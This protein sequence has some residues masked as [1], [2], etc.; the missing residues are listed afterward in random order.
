MPLKDFNEAD[1]RTIRALSYQLGLGQA[2]DD[3]VN[4]VVV[5]A[6][7]NPVPN[8]PTGDQFAQLIQT[9]QSGDRHISNINPMTNGQLS[10]KDQGGGGGNSQVIQSMPGG[11]LPPTGLIGAEQALSGGLTG[12]ESA[13][14]EGA[15]F[16][17][18]SLQSERARGEALIREGIAFGDQTLTTGRD[19]AQQEIMQ[20]Q[21]RFGSDALGIFDLASDPIRQAEQRALSQS[22]ARFDQAAAPMISAT[23]SGVDAN[24][25]M[26]AQSGALGPEAQ[27]AAYNQFN[28]S[29]GQQY[30]Q[31]QAE[32]GLLR[33]Q[34]AIGGLGGGR[35]RQELQRQA[36]GLAQQDFGNQFSRLGQVA[37][38]GQA[39]AGQLGQLRGTQAGLEAGITTGAGQQIG[40]IG[41]Q[42]GGQYLGNVGQ[43]NLMQAQLTGNTAQQVASLGGQGS[44][45]AAQLANQTGAQL[46]NLGGRMGE[47]GA[48][49]YQQTGQNLAQGRTNVGNQLSSNIGGTSS[50][51]ANLINQ[52][53]MAG[54]NLLGE[55]GGNLASILSGSGV[56]QAGLNTNLAT[57][58]ANIATGQ[59]SQSAS[60]P[61]VPGTQQT[62]GTIGAIG[63]A[64]GGIGTLLG[65]I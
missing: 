21:Q 65:A 22:G 41:A 20:G 33:N 9:V 37:G 16:G 29:P 50:A 15:A 8:A 36:M 34:S 59:G 30:L 64:A 6:N 11:R 60:L 14:R 52:Q 25:L 49:L 19:R 58:L 45:Q 61:G 32:R 2:P 4:G 55:T 39:A 35:V 51:L 31:E 27:Q 44:L 13:I 18:D 28:N 54:S 23:L 40:G 17:A 1:Q 3:V 5:D 47:V 48:N 12:A 63:Q 46:A 10:F 38:A 57:I 53:G 26:A 42:L 43:G 56:Q 62:Q 24:Q 7:G